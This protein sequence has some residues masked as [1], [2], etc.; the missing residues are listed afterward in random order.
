MVR[1]LIVY[2]NTSADARCS[3]DHG[4]ACVVDAHGT[5]VLFDT[6]A[7]GALLLHH[8]DHLGVAPASVDQVVISHAHGDHIGG[9][10]AL[11]EI[12]P[13]PV[14]LPASAA[15]APTVARTCPVTGPA[16]IAD[17]LHTTGQMPGQDY[18]L[19]EQSLV[20]KTPA[21]SVV[22]VGCAHPGVDEILRAASRHGRAR[23][24]VGGL[25]GFRDLA[26]L[27]ELDLVCPA[28]CTQ[29]AEEIGRAWPFKVTPGG[30]GRVL[31]FP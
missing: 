4:F 14:H 28:H 20:V 21:G 7:D 1:L 22:V 24:L 26:A 27:S 17:G 19:Q 15:V 3:P 11:L 6:G 9:L 5:R 13:V 2:D 10:D 18:P 31:E 12:A 30:V 16:R 23:A 8:M 29:H 25:H